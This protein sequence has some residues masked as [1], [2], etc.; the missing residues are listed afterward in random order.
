MPRVRRVPDHR[1]LEQP[2]VVRVHDPRAGDRGQ[3]GRPLRRRLLAHGARHGAD[4]QPREQQP[5]EAADEQDRGLAARRAG[6][7]VMTVRAARGSRGRAAR[8]RARATGPARG[9]AAARR[10]PAA[11]GRRERQPGERALGIGGHD[12]DQVLLGEQLVERRGPRRGDGQHHRRA[13]GRDAP[14]GDV[15]FVRGRAGPRRA[16]PADARPGRARR[17]APRAVAP[18]ECRRDPAAAGRRPSRRRP[19]GGRPSRRRRARAARPRWPP[20]H[21]RP[22]SGPARPRR[23]PARPRPGDRAPR[24]W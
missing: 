8:R 24:P 17:A 5:G 19:G 15:S 9:A 21:A 2:P 16:A 3:V 4:D 10:A 22:G 7:L 1:R 14:H 6:A 11:A 12:H 13:H 18:R 20:A 23:P